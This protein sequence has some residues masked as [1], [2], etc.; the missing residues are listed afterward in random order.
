MLAQAA[1]ESGAE[2]REGFAVEE[3][4][5]DED[6]VVGIRGHDRHGASVVEHA[7]VVIGADGAYSTIARMA[8]PAEYNARPALTCWY[9]SYWSGLRRD[10]LRLFSRPQSVFGAI[11][12]NDGLACVAVAW[13]HESF[14]AVKAD[15]ESHYLSALDAAPAF[16]EEVLSGRREERFYGTAHIP[17]YFRKPYGRGW[18]LVGDAGYHKDPILAQGISDALRDAGLLAGALSAVFSGR[19]TWDAALEGYEAARNTAVEQIYRLNLEYASLEPPP[20]EVRR[21]TAALQGNAQDTS[22]FMGTMTGAT[23]VAE[24][25]AEENVARIVGKERERAKAWSPGAA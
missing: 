24:F 4:L 2:M 22:Q 13:P 7:T 6:R 16:K 3:V 1:A 12:T 10:R 14:A 23:P 8:E 15:I 5:F 17:N 21:L 18:A 9:Y 11:P 20:A 25:Y 19:S